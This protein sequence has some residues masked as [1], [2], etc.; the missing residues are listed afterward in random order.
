MP[1]A[2]PNENETAKEL[3]RKIEGRSAEIANV[4]IGYVGLPLGVISP[5]AGFNVNGF[6]VKQ[7]TVDK[8]N[9]GESHIKDIASARVKPLVESGKFHATSDECV[10]DNAD[11]VFMCTDSVHSQ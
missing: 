6:D 11:V 3:R 1:L 8:L 7:E 4:G 9:R 10:L 2:S 5:E